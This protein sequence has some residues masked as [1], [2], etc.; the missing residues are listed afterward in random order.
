MWSMKPPFSGQLPADPQF[1]PWALTLL[2]LT[3]QLPGGERIHPVHPGPVVT[4]LQRGPGVEG[5]WSR[6]QPSLNP[7]PDF[8]STVGMTFV[9]ETQVFSIC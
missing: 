4:V 1:Y 7:L 8:L 6:L 3:T 9:F 2:T 5:N